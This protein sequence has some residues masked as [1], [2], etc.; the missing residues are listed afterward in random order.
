MKWKCLNSNL[1]NYI[2]EEDRVKLDLSSGMVLSIKKCFEKLFGSNFFKKGILTGLARELSKDFG[3][4]LDGSDEDDEVELNALCKMQ[5]ITIFRILDTNGINFDALSEQTNNIVIIRD[6]IHKTPL[7]VVLVHSPL[8]KNAPEK[9]DEK[10]KT[11]IDYLE[12][13]A[14]H[15]KDSQL[16]GS[17]RHLLHRSPSGLDDLPEWQSGSSDDDMTE[18]VIDDDIQQENQRFAEM[19]CKRKTDE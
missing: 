7:Y 16:L 15:G 8:L 14:F 18:D 3:F 6:S 19:F 2:D 5:Q 11:V 13:K 12:Y 10:T 9:I 1:A 17:S 4:V